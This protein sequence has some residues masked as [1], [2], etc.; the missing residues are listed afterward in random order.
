MPNLEAEVN[1]GNFVDTEGKILGK[2]EGYPFYTIG[3]RKGLGLAFGYP[4][5][6]TEIRKDTNEVVLGRHQELE[7]TGMIVSQLNLQKYE[8]LPLP[9]E[10]ITKVRYKDDGT[11]ALITQE[12]SQMHVHFHEPVIGVAPGQAAVF[13]EGDDV[14]GGGW[15]AKSLK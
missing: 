3:Q 10:T 2:H 15:I 6:V 11:P 9:L 5:F 12:G 1:G 4:A 14:V 13:Y 8:S 7:R